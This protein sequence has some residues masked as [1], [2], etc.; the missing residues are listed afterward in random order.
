MEAFG[1]GQ[2]P[3]SG[4]RGLQQ[5][6]QIYNVVTAS[7]DICVCRVQRAMCELQKFQ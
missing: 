6:G 7:F 3:R 1:I 2:G 5:R 4:W